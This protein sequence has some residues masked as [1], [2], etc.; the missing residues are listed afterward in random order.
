MYVCVYGCVCMAVCVCMHKGTCHGSLWGS[1]NKL[2]QSILFFPSVSPGD[3]TQVLRRGG[4]CPYPRSHTAS[5][6]LLL[7]CSWLHAVSWVSLH[8]LNCEYKYVQC[9]LLTAD[10]GT[11]IYSASHR[12]EALKW[13]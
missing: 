3:G 4:K 11:V 10:Q 2:Q 6:V 7:V 12:G 9:F 13:L 5:Q 1:E 8:I